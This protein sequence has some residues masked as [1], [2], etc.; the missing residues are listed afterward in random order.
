MLLRAPRAEDGPL[1]TALIQACPPLDVNSAYCN[2]LQCTHFSDT[3]VVAEDGDRIVGWISAYRPP[4]S[5]DQIFVWQVA[6]HPSARGCGLGQRLIEALLAREAVSDARV[7]TTTITADNAASWAMFQA[8]AKRRDA[9]MCGVPHFESDT[10]FG[11]LHET[12]ILVS[13]APLSFRNHDT[14]KDVL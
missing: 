6:V 12:E 3:C 10:H 1:V 5:P 14:T 4:V 8:F 9:A 11:G 2:L 13:I 7:L